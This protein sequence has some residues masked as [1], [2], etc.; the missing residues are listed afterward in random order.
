MNCIRAIAASITLLALAV[1]AG[2]QT[3][4]DNVGKSS[5]G[6]PAQLVNV[7]FEPQLNVQ[8]PLDTNFRDESGRDV[9]LREYFQG[10]PVLLALVYYGCPML[11]NQVEMGVVGSLKMLSFNA[12]RDYEVVFVS[13]D[14]RETPDMAARKKTAALTRYGRPE[15]AS[16]WHFLTGKEEAIHALTTAANFR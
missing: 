11:C 13:F 9:Q 1:A 2:A 3:I 14:P 7:G 12:G 10:K 5:S 4:P 6:L 15:T 8:L 16:G